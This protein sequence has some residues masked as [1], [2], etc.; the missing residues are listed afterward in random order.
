MGCKVVLI[1]LPSWRKRQDAASS[2]GWLFVLSLPTLL[3]E[4]AFG[5]G[6]L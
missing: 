2:K 1:G 6:R 5:S 3:S 4:L